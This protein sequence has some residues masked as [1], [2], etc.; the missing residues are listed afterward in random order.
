MSYLDLIKNRH[1]REGLTDQPAQGQ[2][3]NPVVNGDAVG[4][5]LEQS[6]AVKVEAPRP[7]IHQCP[8]CKAWYGK[9]YQCGKAR[10]CLDCTE[11]RPRSREKPPA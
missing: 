2:P 6:W 5:D 10:L 8:S 9:L 3:Q 4:L 11:W 1:E 7:L